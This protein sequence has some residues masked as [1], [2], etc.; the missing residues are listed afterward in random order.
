MTDL[1][2]ILPLL[3]KNISANFQQIEGT[4]GKISAQ[5]LRWGDAENIKLLPKPD[6]ILMAD[7]IYYEEVCT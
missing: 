7:V 6:I 3:E 5:T 2:E 1:P 4:G